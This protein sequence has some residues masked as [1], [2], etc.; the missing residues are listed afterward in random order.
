M[1]KVMWIR[2]LKGLCD[3]VLISFE[4]VLPD[5]VGISC[6]F[7][8]NFTYLVQCCQ[9]TKTFIPPPP[10][11]SLSRLVAILSDP[12]LMKPCGERTKRLENKIQVQ[13]HTRSN[14][15]KDT[16]TQIHPYCTV[17]LLG[18]WLLP[19]WLLAI[20]ERRKKT[21][22]TW[23][24]KGDVLIWDSPSK[25]AA[26]DETRQGNTSSETVFRNNRPASSRNGS[27]W[28]LNCLQTC[29]WTNWNLLRIFLLGD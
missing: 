16:E 18:F 13:L 14:L 8:V 5:A 3:F 7:L 9:K 29:G 15:R 2:P 24:N 1:R 17:G 6:C 25:R 27:F 22:E 23:L 20:S 11:P 26:L 12:E 4:E 21:S 10:P 28:L 19:R